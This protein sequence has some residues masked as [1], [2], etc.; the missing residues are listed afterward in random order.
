[1]NDRLKEM[2]FGPYGADSLKH[3][4]D[5]KKYGVNAV[6]FH[7]FDENAFSLC[8]ANDLAACVEY[9]T[10]RADFDKNPELIPV[11]MDGKPIR[12]GSLVQGVCLSNKEFLDKTESDL[13]EGIKQFHP[14]GIWL[15]YLTYAGWFETPDPDLQE[16]CFCQSCMNDFCETTGLD[17][18]DPVR[19]LQQLPEEWKKHKCDRI[20]AYAI[21]YAAC[22]HSIRP[23]CI[24]GAYMCPWLPAEQ[25]GAL[26]RIFA[27]DYEKMAAAIDVFTPLIYASKSGRSNAWGKEFLERSESFV[28]VDKKVQ[29]ILDHLDFPKSLEM[30]ALSEKQSWGIQVY[31]GSRIFDN[32][33]HAEIFREAVMKIK[34]AET[35]FHQPS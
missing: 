11:G 30:T 8:E 32:P 19:V 35:G 24:V 25:E 16:S 9:K 33:V 23:D 17:V 18:D 1:M 3:A 10:F 7:G 29:L 31:S 6:W 14:K 20:A 4:G 5:M 27:Q 28:P 12:Y 15:D 21:H 34:Q 13:L 2:L 22:I 26:S